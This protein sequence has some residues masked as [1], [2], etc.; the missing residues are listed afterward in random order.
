[1]FKACVEGL[2]VKLAL[3]ETLFAVAEPTGTW[4]CVTVP[5]TTPPRTCEGSIFVCARLVDGQNDATD[6][7]SSIESNRC[8]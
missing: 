2:K 4:F 7:R 6:G 3:P 8:P 5:P 1:M